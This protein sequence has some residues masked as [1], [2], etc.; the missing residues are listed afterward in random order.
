LILSLTFSE[1]G[2]PFIAGVAVA[3]ALDRGP[4]RRAYVVA[5]PLVLY[6]IWYLGWGHT[7]TS[8]LSFHNVANS[9]SYVLDG[10]A[11]SIGSLLG[12]STPPAL[13]GAGGI[14]WGRPLLVGLVVLAC[15]RLWRLGRFPATLWVPLAIGVSFWFLTA[16]NTGF[17]RAPTASRYQYV[18]AVFVLMIAAELVR[19]WRPGWRALTTVGVATA[20]AAAA[21][22]A[23]MHDAY[24]VFRN[25]TAI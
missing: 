20:L 22:V 7:A 15:I 12:L 17:G 18:G 3:I 24:K 6:A 13:G 19:G 23:A 25:W 9:P 4:W 21:N 2:I 1:L 16:A 8:Y 10:L 5:V 14:E 11:S